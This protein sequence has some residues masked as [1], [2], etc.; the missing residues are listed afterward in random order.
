MEFNGT[1]WVSMI[2]FT[3]FVF[4]MNKVL[5]EPVE[6]IIMQRESFINGNLSSASENRKRADVLVSERDKKIEAAKTKAREKYNSLINDCK[7]GK[8]DIL[9]EAQIKV[10]DDLLQSYED[11]NRISA[12]TKKSLENKIPELAEDITEKLLK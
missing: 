11:L 5:Y 6:K 1:F 7:V 8:N 2:S 9:Q 4:L 10:K 12:E 3:V